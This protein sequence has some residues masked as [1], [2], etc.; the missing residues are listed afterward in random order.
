[1]QER[2]STLVAQKFLYPSIAKVARGYGKFIKHLHKAGGFSKLNP[3]KMTKEILD[4]ACKSVLDNAEEVF[5]AH[6]D[7][8]MEI[9]PASLRIDPDSPEGK[10]KLENLDAEVCMDL[11]PSALEVNAGFFTKLLRSI[12]DS[13][14]SL[15][16]QRPKKT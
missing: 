7:A 8:I 3:E 13:I 1:M 5:G 16:T 14:F 11:F 6:G 12:L 4:A 15:S 9:V 10:E 2:D